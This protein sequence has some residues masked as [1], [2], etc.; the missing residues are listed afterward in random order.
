MYIRNSERSAIARVEKG[1]IMTSS[2]STLGYV[3]N[4]KE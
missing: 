4:G 2:R 1:R 3:E